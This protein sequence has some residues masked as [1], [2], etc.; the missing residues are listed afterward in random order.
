MVPWAYQLKYP[1]CVYGLFSLRGLSAYFYTVENVFQ[2]LLFYFVNGILLMCVITVSL[3]LP[4]HQAL[5]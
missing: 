3:P 5:F 1:P 2:W 4:V